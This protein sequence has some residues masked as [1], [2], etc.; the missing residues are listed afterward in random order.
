MR[1]ISI[2]LRDRTSRRFISE[3]RTAAVQDWSEMR[4]PLPAPC[5]WHTEARFRLEFTKLK[6]TIRMSKAWIRRAET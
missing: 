3:Q 5:T 1:A 6:A 4:G 2:N